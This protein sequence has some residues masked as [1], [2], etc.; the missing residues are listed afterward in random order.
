MRQEDGDLDFLCVTNDMSVDISPRKRS[1]AF[2]FFGWFGRA[3]QRA[4]QIMRSFVSCSSL[5]SD[6]SFGEYLSR[7]LGEPNSMVLQDSRDASLLA[8]SVA[9]DAC[10]SFKSDDSFSQYFANALR[11]P[12]PLCLRGGVDQTP[13]TGSLP[14][15]ACSSSKSD[16]S[17]AEYLAKATRGHDGTRGHNTL[18]FRESRDGTDLS[19]CSVPRD[20]CSSPKS[21]ASHA[22]QYLGCTKRVVGNRSRNFSTFQDPTGVSRSL[23]NC[24]VPGEA[25]PPGYVTPPDVWSHRNGRKSPVGFVG[26]LDANTSTR[27]AAICKSQK[28]QIFERPQP[29]TTEGSDSGVTSTYLKLDQCQCIGENMISSVSSAQPKLPANFFDLP[30]KLRLRAAKQFLEEFEYRLNPISNFQVKKLRPLSGLMATAKL[31]IYKP[32]PIKC[33]E[34]VFIALYLTAGL[35]SV[36]RIPLGFKTQFA[37]QVFQHVVLLVQYKGKYGAFGISRSPDLMNKDLCFDSMSSIIENFKTA[38]EETD[39]TILNLQI[40]LPVEHD[41]M[42]GNFVCWEHLL[43]YPSVQPW[44]E[45]VAAIENHALRMKHLWNVWVISGRG[46]DPT[47]TP[48]KSLRKPPVN[49]G[50]KSVKLTIRKPSTLQKNSVKQSEEHNTPACQ[51]TI[52]YRVPYPPTRMTRNDCH[53]FRGQQNASVYSGSTS[54]RSLLKGYFDPKESTGP[55]KY[56]QCPKHHDQ[57]T[58]CTDSVHEN[59]E[60]SVTYAGE[61]GSLEQNPWEVCKNFDCRSSLCK[62]DSKRLG[63][64]PKGRG[65][66]PLYSMVLKRSRAG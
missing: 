15:K 18:D 66:G 24:S 32:E 6:D 4:V 19:T 56:T 50:P 44:P 60:N 46:S 40:G 64:N 21:D 51:Q 9:R 26:K 52:S 59:E 1:Q 45:C 55:W 43:L 8:C 13:S 23:S 41:V 38:Y 16:D 61:C 20:A 11:D 35:Q 47:R 14:L 49:D 57:G 29:V 31:I 63:D 39:H 17:F 33:V 2:N 34:A 58:M 12:S 42:S 54:N 3:S 30:A 53:H 27:L 22:P 28:S 48:S 7:I 65:S 5:Q 10:S 36:E 25:T 37:N 62:A